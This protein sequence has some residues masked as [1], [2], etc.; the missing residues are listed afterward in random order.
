M[1]EIAHNNSKLPKQLWLNDGLFEAVLTNSISG[2]EF[3]ALITLR[4]KKTIHDFFK[5]FFK[6]IFL[7]VL[8]PI[9]LPIAIVIL[10]LY[11]MSVPILYFT[12]SR[13]TSRLIAFKQNIENNIKLGKISKD[14]LISNHRDT[15]ELIDK[16]SL[17]IENYKN[18]AIISK[19]IHKLL[20]VLKEIEMIE[21]INAFPEENEIELTYDELKQLEAELKGWNISCNNF[22][23]ESITG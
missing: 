9:I 10:F 20:C 1:I 4:I 23:E 21:R 8:I 13:L 5:G 16:I 7:I 14:R 19:R 12:L 3:L 11:L 18:E 17:K 2:F 6:S 15:K 22:T